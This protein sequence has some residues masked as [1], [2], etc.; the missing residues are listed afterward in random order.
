MK[1][2]S[3]FR[4]IDNNWNKSP[5]L[6]MIYLFYFSQQYKLLCVFCNEGRLH[7]MVNISTQLW[8][9]KSNLYWFFVDVWYI[10]HRVDYGARY[11]KKWKNKRLELCKVLFMFIMKLNE[12]LWLWLYKFVVEERVVNFCTLLIS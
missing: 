11:K 3:I 5:P 12:M 1:K 4:F 6:W 8:L 10:L 7:V 2:K 9:L